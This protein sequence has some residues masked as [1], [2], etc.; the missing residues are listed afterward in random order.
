MQVY[1]P[2]ADIYN[3]WAV[4][5]NILLVAGKGSTLKGKGA[6]RKLSLSQLL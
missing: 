1:S 6:H 5:D 4:G 3:P 2:V